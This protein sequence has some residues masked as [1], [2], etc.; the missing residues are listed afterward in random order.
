M[1]R[2]HRIKL[3]A[4]VSSHRTHLHALVSSPRI[5]LHALVSSHRIH[6]EVLRRRLFHLP[7]LVAVA[8]QQL[9]LRG[10]GLPADWE[11]AMSWDEKR[12]EGNEVSSCWLPAWKPLLP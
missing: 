7:T 9:L 12:W 2:S 10:I 4:L 5:H 1:N 6:Y 11:G 3:H 8:L